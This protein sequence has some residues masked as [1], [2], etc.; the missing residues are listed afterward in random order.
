[1]SH[2]ITPGQLSL[3]QYSSP[4]QIWCSELWHKGLKYF[5]P[6]YRQYGCRKSSDQVPDPSIPKKKVH[7]IKHFI[8]KPPGGGSTGASAGG[9][10]AGA[11]GTGGGTGGAGGTGGST[12]G[13]DAGGTGGAGAGGTGRSTGRAGVG[14]TGGAGAGGSGGSTGGAG[15]GGTGG[16]TCGAGAGGTRGGSAGDGGTGGG[17]AGEAGDGAG[18]A[19]SC[20]TSCLMSSSGTQS[21]YRLY[22]LTLFHSLHHNLL[23]YKFSCTSMITG[24]YK[25]LC[26]FQEFFT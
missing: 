25:W 1:M 24:T 9:A 7:I 10:G 20:S 26:A 23:S 11:G 13:T 14:G 19:A 4:K 18:T 21:L 6:C 16:G 15:A 8:S 5:P 17:S 12:G 22:N 3:F 2:R